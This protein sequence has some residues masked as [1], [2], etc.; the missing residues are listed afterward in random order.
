MTTKFGWRRQI[1]K[2][3]NVRSIQNWPVQSH[4]AEMMRAAAIAATEAGLRI[5][6]PIHDAFL[7]EAPLA[8]IETDAAALQAIMRAAGA[9]VI[10]VPVETDVKFIRPPERYMDKR[11]AEMWRSVM[12]HLAE[13][14]KAT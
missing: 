8:Q 2:N 12:G 11:G 3:P 14:G 1:T 5:C 6:C 10:G 7:L 13:I 4:G 9:A